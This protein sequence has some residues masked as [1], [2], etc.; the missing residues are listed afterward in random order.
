MCICVVYVYSDIDPSSA[1]T[2]T[3]KQ[4]P[5]A[6]H[7]KVLRTRTFVGIGSSLVRFCM[8]MGSVADSAVT[9][10]LVGVCPSLVPLKL[11]C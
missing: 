4:E 5:S 1:A 9:P 10:T 3:G 2:N 7:N 8:G 11:L 6:S